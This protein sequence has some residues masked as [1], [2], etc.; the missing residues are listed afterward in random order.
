MADIVESER[1]DLKLSNP[2]LYA[3]YTATGASKHSSFEEYVADA[4]AEKYIKQ[5]KDLEKDISAQADILAE[6]VKQ[7]EA[8]RADLR[9]K[10]K[11]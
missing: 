2:G 9:A 1:Q 8:K 7:E 5:Y 10:R 6:Q 3:S 11:K 4:E